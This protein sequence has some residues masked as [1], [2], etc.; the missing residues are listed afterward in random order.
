MESG[1]VARRLSPRIVSACI[2]AFLAS[3]ALNW[4]AFPFNARLPDVLFLVAAAALIA[5]RPSPL[6]FHWLDVLIILYI[7]GAL[8]SL[9]ATDD[10]TISGIELARQ[11]YLVAVYLVVAVAVANGYQRLVIVALAAGGVVLAAIGLGAALVHLFQPLNVAALGEVMTLPY[12]GSVLRLRGF[13]ASPAMLASALTMTIGFS[14]AAICARVSDDR[15]WLRTAVAIS[16]VAALLTFSHALAGLIVTIVV[17]AWQ[18]L[19]RS[20]TS[21]LLAVAA[22]T[23]V[24]IVFNGGLIASARSVRIG[25]ST[26]I[27]EAAFHQAVERRSIDAGAIHVEYDVVSY[28][29][30]KEIAASTLLSHPWTG[31]GL[32]RFHVVTESAYRAGR[33]PSMYRAADPHSSLLGRLAETGLLGGVT[34]GFLWFG[35]GGL[36]WKLGRAAHAHAWIAWGVFAAFIGLVISAINLD[37]MNF[38]F[39][40]AG[41]GVVRGLAEGTRL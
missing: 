6:R 39:L 27:D 14:V 9:L 15:G 26:F 13:A 34:L 19:R 3:L 36:G 37:I 32:D 1:Q 2:A 21:R 4:P 31:V 25:N 12:V 22:A 40:W 7:A 16:L 35:A 8:P 18:C 17:A 10:L 20:R 23:I 41:L 24:V 30:L 29:R 38:R 5:T 33:L 28:F 11:V